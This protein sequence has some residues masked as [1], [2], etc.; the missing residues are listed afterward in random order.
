M[1]KADLID[2]TFDELRGDASKAVIGKVLEGLVSV[3]TQAL[4]KGEDVPL[5]GLGKFEAVQRAARTGR[6]PRTGDV[7]DIPA[8][9]AVKL[10]CSKTLKDALN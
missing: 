7:I 1:T 9:V 5:T 6:N 4:K 10:S 2:L 3:S 8:S